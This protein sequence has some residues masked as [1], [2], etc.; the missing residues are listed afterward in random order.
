MRSLASRFLI[1][2]LAVLVVGR[3][4]PGIEVSGLY[5]ACIVAV[6]RSLINVTLKPVLFILILPI[7]LL[8]LGLFSFVINAFLF[9]F[10][11]TFVE[12]FAVAGFFSA[13]IG[14]V[15]ISLISWAGNRFV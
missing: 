2:L 15:I 13:L 14:T 7:N 4:I 8:K 5:I 10:V 9:W 6:L 1:T 12:G 11:A 3:F